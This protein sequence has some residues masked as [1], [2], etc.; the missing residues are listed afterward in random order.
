MTVQERGKVFDQI[1]FRNETL[2][3]DGNTYTGC[4]FYDCKL[5]FG[6]VALP[7]FRGCRLDKADWVFVDGAANMVSFLSYF[8]HE[9]GASGEQL[10]DKLFQ[11]IRQNQVMPSDIPVLL[12]E[13]SATGSGVATGRADLTVSRSPR[14]HPG[15]NKK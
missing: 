8:F 1:I 13:L 9:F 6:S 11:E 3:V 15:D 2:R 7:I 14:W 12:A 5:E 4:E 10:V